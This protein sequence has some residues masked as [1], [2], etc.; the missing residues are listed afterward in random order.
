MEVDPKLVEETAE[1][2]F[3][4]APCGYLSTLPDGTI[5]RTNQTFLD[6]TGHPRDW[7]MAGRRFLTWWC[8]RAWM[9]AVLCCRALMRRRTEHWRCCRG[10]WRKSG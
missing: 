2:L 10:G 6:L 3:E 4:H 1:A 8:W 7:L 5:V 9:A